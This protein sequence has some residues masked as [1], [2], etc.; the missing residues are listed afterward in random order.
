METLQLKNIS[1]FYNKELPILQNINISFERGKM[2][3]ILGKSGS[4]KT[5]LLSLLAGL[6]EPVD[7]VILYE[8]NILKGKELDNYRAKH[9]SIIFQ[10]YNLI[11][12]LTAV[13]NIEFIT[14]KNARP[15]LHELGILEEDMDRNVLQLSGGQQQRV[16]IGRALTS[17]TDILLAD[18]P[19]GN[20]DEK[21][22]KEIA[23]ILKNTAYRKKKCVIV[24]THSSE[25]AKY[26]DI[27]L[28]LEKGKLLEERRDT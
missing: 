10:S 28:N 7:G 9:V 22:A 11:D 14:N 5:T 2:Y 23:E 13:E 8:G 17:E 3:A 25:V 15:I 21:T 4:G 16:A 18:E 24:V 26:A 20:L 6:D 12:Y 19:T 1:Y 27:V